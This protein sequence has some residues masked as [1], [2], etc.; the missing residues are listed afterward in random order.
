VSDE[1]I[2]RLIRYP[3]AIAMRL[4]IARLRL[5][6]M[7]IG[8][9]CWVRAI[10]VPRNPWDICLG[11]GAALDDDVIL[12]TSGS[13]LSSPRLS[14]GEKTYVNRF[15]MFDV[16]ESMQIGSYCMIGPYCY[17]TDHDHGRRMDLPIGQQPLI[18]A[19]V[20]IGDHVWIGAGAYILKGVKIGDRVIVGA[21]AV[22]TREVS[23]GCIVA[24]VP[25]R[26]INSRKLL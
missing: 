4:R 9:R 16:S 26:E 5:L 8:D 23:P 14:I 11:D 2:N 3:S 25:A 1:L 10:R 21:G 12:L 18:S 24:G 22:V 19:P 20:V 6:G 13:R 15:T 17:L 7:T